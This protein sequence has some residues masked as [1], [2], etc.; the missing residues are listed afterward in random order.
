MQ[1]FDAWPQPAIMRSKMLD[2][3]KRCTLE[4]HGW[5][6]KELQARLS[7]DKRQI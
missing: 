3:S 6:A 1:V 2:S 7:E 5:R 4:E